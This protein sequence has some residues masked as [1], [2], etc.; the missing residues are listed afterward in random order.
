MIDIE[1]TLQYNQVRRKRIG[2]KISSIWSGDSIFLGARSYPVLDF[3]YLTSN[4]SDFEKNVFKQ[5]QKMIYHLSGYGVQYNE[6]FAG[7]IGESAERYTFASF[8]N[9]IREFAITAS[10]QEMCDKY[11]KDNVCELSL[12]NSY[13]DKKDVNQYVIKEDRLQWIGMNS[14]LNLGEKIY[15]PLQFV[16][17]NNGE[18]FAKEKPFMTSAVSTGTACHENIQ[19]AF[20]NAAV[21]Y[22]QIDSFNLWW[23]GGVK[24]QE[25]NIDRKEFLNKY[26]KCQEKVQK[27]L[28]NFD[29]NFTDIS[30]DKDIDI[31][32]CE[33]FAKKE[34]LPKYTVGVQGGIGKEK[35]LY[36]GL[37]EAL[38]VLEY[39]MNLPWMDPEKYRTITRKSTGINNLDDNV[40]LYAKYGKPAK[41]CSKTEMFND[42]GEKTYNVLKNIQK[43]S[44]YAGYLILTIPE[45]ENMNLEV[46][47]VCIPE[48]LPLCLPSYPPYYH[49]RYETTG[50]IRN[51]VPHPLA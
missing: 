29:V 49:K 8:Y 18:I 46:V 16:V 28:K 30:Y 15:I 12:L 35:V 48:L 25:I 37:M 31:V 2:S 47:R 13:F 26:F 38:A 7:Y 17:S 9:L 42:P 51:N 14:L 44:K 20:E 34:N 40:I 41:I 6:A 39:N 5:K 10:Y 19:K 36:R 3:T 50:G 45:F 43:M 27:F 24:G 11:G 21:E 32:V 22:L 1:N 23:Y 33:I 4:F